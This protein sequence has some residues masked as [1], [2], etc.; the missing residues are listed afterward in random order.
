[1]QKSNGPKFP[2]GSTVRVR[3]NRTDD[4]CP[5]MPFGGWVGRVIEV[6][7]DV[8]TTCLV[9]WSQE[10]LAAIRRPFGHPCEGGRMGFRETWLDEDD[11]EHYD[12]IPLPVEQPIYTPHAGD[13]RDARIRSALGLFSF[14]LLPR[15]CRDA[16]LTY[17]EHFAARLSF[18]FDGNFQRRTEPLSGPR[19]VTVVRLLQ[20][21]GVNE[22]DGILCRA[23]DGRGARGVPLADVQVAANSANSQLITDYC[24]WFR[25]YR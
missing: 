21:A 14:D 24:Y 17:Y 10:T 13:D 1:M 22:S 2:V 18:P 4:G 16:L 3:W 11:M 8:C 19:C 20:K 15:A 6:H 9:R 12:G 23:V 7:K 25:N 5:D